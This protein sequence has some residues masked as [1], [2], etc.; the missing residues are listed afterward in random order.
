[1]VLVVDLVV[2]VAVGVEVV[3][4]V[5]VAVVGGL[6]SESRVSICV[7]G[8]RGHHQRVDHVENLGVVL[9]VGLG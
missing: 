8:C 3:A 1:M 6:I 9:I 2:I 5:L 7:H 4:R